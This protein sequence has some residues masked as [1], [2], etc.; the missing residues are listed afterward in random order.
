MHNSNLITSKHR[1]KII[2][3]SKLGFSWSLGV[4]CD[5][6]SIVAG[7]NFSQTA[8]NCFCGCGNCSCVT[9]KLVNCS[10]FVGS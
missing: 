8:G 6:C 5:G 2:M 9:V 3:S 7:N 1:L 4:E 10:D